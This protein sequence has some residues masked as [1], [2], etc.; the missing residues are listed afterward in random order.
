MLKYSC[1]IALKGT[2]RGGERGRAPDMRPRIMVT[3]VVLRR[4]YVGRKGYLVY[5]MEKNNNW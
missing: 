1:N 2:Y 5:G 3:V 4:S